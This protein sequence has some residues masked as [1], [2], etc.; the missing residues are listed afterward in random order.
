[1]LIVN[2]PLEPDMCNWSRITDT[3]KKAEFIN[4]SKVA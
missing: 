3:L 2:Y 1:M 4:L